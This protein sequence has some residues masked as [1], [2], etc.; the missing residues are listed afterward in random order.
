MVL[1][2]RQGGHKQAVKNHHTTRANVRGENISIQGIHLQPRRRCPHNQPSPVRGLLSALMSRPGRYS[3]PP[4]YTPVGGLGPGGGAGAVEAVDWGDVLRH[5]GDNS[6]WLPDSLVSASEQVAEYLDVYEF[7]VRYCEI[8]LA[9]CLRL[10]CCG[11]CW[12]RVMCSQHTCAL[13]AGH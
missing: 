3:A 10:V 7:H 13:S 6:V 2:A 8:E 5:I 12:W 11:A 9:T 4:S 1:S